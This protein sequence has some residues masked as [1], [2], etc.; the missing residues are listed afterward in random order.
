MAPMVGPRISAIDGR[1]V[2]S[3]DTAIVL[4]VQAVMAQGGR[5]MAWSQERLAIPRG[6]VSSVRTRTLDRKRTWLIAG[7]S[8]VGV[9]ALG[10]VFGLGTG[11]DGLL[12]GG[13]SGGRK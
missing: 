6:A 12:G 4:S 9:I 8:V 1:V 5:S 10:D 3:A 11:F 2:S 7:L 13:G